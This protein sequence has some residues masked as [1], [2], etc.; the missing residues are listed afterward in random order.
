MTNENSKEIMNVRNVA[1]YLG[2]STAKIYQ[3][4]KQKRIPAS[5]IGKKYFFTKD[6]IV[7]WLKENLI[8][9]IEQQNFFKK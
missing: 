5:K 6:L 7:K 3:L 2:L 1:K 4:I 8:T 9:S